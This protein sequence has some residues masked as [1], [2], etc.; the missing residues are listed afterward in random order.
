M[1]YAIRR[2]SG[3]SSTLPTDRKREMS[4][5]AKPCA[6]LQGVEA[7]SAIVEKNP[8]TTRRRTKRNCEGMK[9]TPEFSCDVVLAAFR[10]NKRLPISNIDPST[11]PS[12][13]KRPSG[14]P[15]RR[16]NA[17]VRGWR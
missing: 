15:D 11:R 5:L 16:E 8:E 12:S 2:P 1:V 10:V 14:E 9:S 4:L 7:R 17:R 3:E 13:D 6:S